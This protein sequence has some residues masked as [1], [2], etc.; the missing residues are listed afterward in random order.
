[1]LFASVAFHVRSTYVE[2]ALWYKTL[3]VNEITGDRQYGLACAV[4]LPVIEGSIE[5]SGQT[6]KLEGHVIV[7]GLLQQLS[8]TVMVK[9]HCAEFP[10]AS[11]ATYRTV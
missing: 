1:V 9:L 7:G 10:H 4:A 6:V 8:V 3:S 11:V 5:E 2:H